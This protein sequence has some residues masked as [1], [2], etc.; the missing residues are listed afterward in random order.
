MSKFNISPN[1]F[2]VLR[3]LDKNSRL[4]INDISKICGINR[5]TVR[6]IIKDLQERG[7]IKKFTVELNEINQGH[8]LL[9]E[10][11]NLEGVPEDYVIQEMKLANGNYL[12]LCTQDILNRDIKYIKMNVV[13]EVVR[14]HSLVNSVKIYCDYCGK[15]ITDTPIE[16]SINNR[17]YYACCHNCERDLKRMYKN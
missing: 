9:L 15:E 17:I 14:R 16:I 1:E 5:N 12:L 11:E 6:K 4:S 2:K 7:I 3:T 13:R 8:N 10:V